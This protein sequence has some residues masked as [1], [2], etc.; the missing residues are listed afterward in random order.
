MHTKFESDTEG[1]CTKK[2]KLKGLTCFVLEP[3]GALQNVWG[4]SRVRSSYRGS[5]RLMCT[6]VHDEALYQSLATFPCSFFEDPHCST[7]E[8]QKL[9][10]IKIWAKWLKMDSLKT[11]GLVWSRALNSPAY[12]CSASSRASKDAKRLI[13]FTK[14]LSCAPRTVLRPLHMTKLIIRVQLSFPI[15]L[16]EIPQ[17]KENLS[18][19]IYT[20]D[21]RLYK[22]YRHMPRIYFSLSHKHI[23]TNGSQIEDFTGSTIYFYY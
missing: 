8:L 9:V 23:L 20:W 12:N 18:G 5:L 14:D 11:S 13:G 4:S 1:D 10:Y 17:P 16:L 7:Q 3:E 6:H 21:S 2:Y 22:L 15:V 19:I